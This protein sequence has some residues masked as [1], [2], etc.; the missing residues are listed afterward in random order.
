LGQPRVAL[1]N[2]LGCRTHGGERVRACAVD[3]ARADREGGRGGAQARN[4]ARGGPAVCQKHDDDAVVIVSHGARR[5]PLCARRPTRVWGWGTRKR[6]GGVPGRVRGTSS[7]SMSPSAT[8]WGLGARGGGLLALGGEWRGGGGGLTG[9]LPLLV[10]L[11]LLL[12]LL[13]PPLCCDFLL[14]CP[15]AGWGQG[16]GGGGGGSRRRW[17][18][19]R[20]PLGLGFCKRS[21][22]DLVY[23]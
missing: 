13:L 8:F 11:S 7:P 4:G 5:A 9:G 14:G 19:R 20:N 16:G 2:P 22:G 3:C 15:R 6:G 12:P 23:G 18:C 21:L 17:L 10:S 1:G